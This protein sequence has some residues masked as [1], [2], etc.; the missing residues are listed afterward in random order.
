MVMLILRLVGEES[1][2]ILLIRRR[3]ALRL[4]DCSVARSNIAFTAPP[5]K[6]S[7]PVGADTKIVITATVTASYPT[8]VKA[9]HVIFKCEICTPFFALFNIFL[10]FYIYFLKFC[11]SYDVPPVYVVTVESDVGYFL[12]LSPYL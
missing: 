7:R 12:V 5:S 3:N 9:F 1:Q 4:P 6:K 11:K 10:I 2:L 8:T